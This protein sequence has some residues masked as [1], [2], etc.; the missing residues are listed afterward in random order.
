MTLVFLSSMLLVVVVH[1]V[2]VGLNPTFNQFHSS[3]GVL[4]KNRRKNFFFSLVFMFLPWL[5]KGFVS[6]LKVGFIHFPLL[7]PTK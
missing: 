3:F 1:L 4:A 5:S 6:L 2:F 7:Y